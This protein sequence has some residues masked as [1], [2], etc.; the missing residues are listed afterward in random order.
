MTYQIQPPMRDLQYIKS[1]FDYDP[2]T[3]L[4]KWKPVADNSSGWNTKYAG[5]YPSATDSLGYIRAK[6]T[7]GEWSGYCS[8]HRICFFIHNGYLP[9][10]VDHVN[11]DVK[12]NRACNLRAADFERNTW[13]RKPNEGTLTGRKGVNAIKYRGGGPSHGSICGYTARIGHG[14][15][16][17]YLGFFR[18]YESA[19]AAYDKREL[20]LRAEYVRQ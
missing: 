6:I 13:N 12:D 19:S 8:V 10:V 16:R 11:G 9:E 1:R 20:E 5:T 14:G 17:E 7:L 15:D 3:G 18:D 4:L 2:E